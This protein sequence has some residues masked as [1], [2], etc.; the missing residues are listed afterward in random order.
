VAFLCS[1]AASHIT[2]QVFGVQGGL[3]QL[4]QS[5]TPVSELDKG[6]RWEVG[7]LAER[8]DEL[9]QDR[10]TT[11]TPQRSPLRRLAGIGDDS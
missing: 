8:M 10:P 9:F 11:Y 4:Y 7:E 3:V 2:G 5:W 6:E 1:D